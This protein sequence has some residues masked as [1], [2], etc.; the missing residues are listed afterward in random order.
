MP[1]HCTA[2][3]A[4]FVALSRA[5]AVQLAAVDRPV[6]MSLDGEYIAVH[7]TLCPTGI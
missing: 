6:G 2:L 7:S 1:V 4:D 5:A 3:D